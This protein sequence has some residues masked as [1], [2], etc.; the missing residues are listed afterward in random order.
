MVD[1]GKIVDSRHELAL[2]HLAQCNSVCRRC[3]V[4]SML[5]ALP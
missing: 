5:S 3:R 4:H 1:K 2:V